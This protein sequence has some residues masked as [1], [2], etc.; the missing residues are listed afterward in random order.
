MI[1]RCTYISY[2]TSCMISPQARP[3][4]ARKRRPYVRLPHELLLRE[5][6]LIAAEA[7]RLPDKVRTNGVVTDV[8]RFPVIDVHCKRYGICG[9]L[10]G[11]LF[12]S[13]QMLLG[14]RAPNRAAPAA[15][16]PPAPSPASSRP[17][18]PAR[19]GA[20]AG[21]SF[22]HCKGRE[23]ATTTAD[24]YFQH[25]FSCLDKQQT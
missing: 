21:L 8:P 13:W 6:H 25:G 5:P 20:G 7:R 18:R 11:E 24:S 17:R 23:P 22:R 3:E 16:P 10:C 2:N 14:S 15:S 4:P 9:K 12:P 1:P 19:G